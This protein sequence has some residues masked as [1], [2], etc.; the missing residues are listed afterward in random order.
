MDLMIFVNEILHFDLDTLIS[1]AHMRKVED[2]TRVLRKIIESKT[3]SVDLL[4]CF[5]DALEAIAC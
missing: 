4:N 2:L 5:E 1:T 3:R